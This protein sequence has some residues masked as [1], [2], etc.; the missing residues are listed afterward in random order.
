MISL[1]IKNDITL[2]LVTKTHARIPYLRLQ[3]S[4]SYSLYFYRQ[5]KLT[6]G[7]LQLVSHYLSMYHFCLVRRANEKSQV[8]GRSHLATT[9][10]YFVDESN[11]TIYT[12]TRL[13]GIC[14]VGVREPFLFEKGL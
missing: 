8:E 6:S 1:Q 5:R 14:P 12:E 3:L 4:P 10:D 9:F 13:W 7:F 11:H 2:R